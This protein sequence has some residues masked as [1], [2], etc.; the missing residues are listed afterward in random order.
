VPGSDKASFSSPL[1]D[2]GAL[3]S[4]D[5]VPLVERFAFCII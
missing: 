1:Q 3:F 4:T 5:T 2:V